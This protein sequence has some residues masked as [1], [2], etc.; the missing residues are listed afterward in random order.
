MSTAADGWG[1]RVVGPQLDYDVQVTSLVEASDVAYE[2]P[3]EGAT[4]SV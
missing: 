4:A 2:A 1:L 3:Q